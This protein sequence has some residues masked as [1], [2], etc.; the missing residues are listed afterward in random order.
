LAARIAG[1]GCPLLRRTMPLVLRRDSR[2]RTNIAI[3]QRC[4]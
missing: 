2:V 4:R 3:L 1:V